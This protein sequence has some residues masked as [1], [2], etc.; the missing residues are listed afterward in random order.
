MG[1]SVDGGGKIY[2]ILSCFAI[3]KTSSK[4]IVSAVITVSFLAAWKFKLLEHT[5]SVVWQH[6]FPRQQK[7]VPLLLPANRFCH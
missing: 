4:G 6:R 1:K 2:K 5:E 7:P 3:R